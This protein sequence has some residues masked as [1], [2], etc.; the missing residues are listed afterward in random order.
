MLIESSAPYRHRYIESAAPNWHWYL[1]DQCPLSCVKPQMSVARCRCSAHR[2]SM[3]TA[4]DLTGSVIGRLT[5][6]RHAGRQFVGGRMRHCWEVRCECGNTLVIDTGPLRDGRTR[7]CGCLRTEMIVA[8]STKHGFGGRTTRTAEYRIWRGMKQRCSDPN[9]LAWPD[10]G[11]RGI[12]VCDRWKNDFE[13]FLADMGPRPSARHSIDRIDVNGH[14]EPGNCR[15]A[16]QK[17]QCRNTR[18]NRFIE[19]DGKRALLIEWAERLGVDASVV[20]GRL[21]RGW[22]ERDAVSKPR[23]S[24]GRRP[25]RG[26]A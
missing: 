18:R 17:E 26:A 5:V 25:A 1:D 10:Y 23:M 2:C 13:A 19:V 9:C 16:T 24:N 20:E 11:G 21:A 3:P 15:W 4:I 14:Y 6:L 7:S 12:A 8:R 22:S